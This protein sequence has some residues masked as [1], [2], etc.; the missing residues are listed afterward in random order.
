MGLLMAVYSTIKARPFSTPEHIRR[1]ERTDE[2]FA[3]NLMLLLKSFQ[4]LGYF[5]ELNDIP[6]ETVRISVFF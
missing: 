3:L 1:S 2:I 6:V 5:I 4:S